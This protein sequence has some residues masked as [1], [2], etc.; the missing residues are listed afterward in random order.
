M[1]LS[2]LCTRMNFM[3]RR[4]A[5]IAGLVLP[6]ALLGSP[7]HGLEPAKAPPEIPV[8]LFALTHP[9]GQQRL[10][11]SS[12]RQAYWPLAA[13]F[14][15]QR[16]QA[17]CSVATSVVAL[18]ALGVARPMTGL[19]PDYR[20]F[21]QQ[22]FFEGVDPRIAQPDVVAKEGMTLAQLGHVLASQPVR[23]EVIFADTLDLSQL[24]LLLMKHL[25]EQDRFVLFNF[26]RR[27]LGEAGGGH[28]SPLAAYHE[29][30]DSALLM[31]VARYKYPPVWV[32]L[33]E[34]LQS[35][36]DHDSVSGKARGMIVL[37]GR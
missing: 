18:N 4:F 8:Q 16:N 6:L 26:N 32:P 36:Q 13:Y 12:Y 35:A 20:F 25:R 31:D 11:E 21:T 23:A 10:I 30:S 2:S 22:D 3:A 33:V 7:V 17:Y 1:A 9:I 27:I 5:M 14:E 15:T 19:Y 24:R 28:W 29:A 37:S 34:L